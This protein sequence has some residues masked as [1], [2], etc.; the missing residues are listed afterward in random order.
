MYGTI[1]ARGNHV[2]RRGNYVF[3]SFDA[4][5]RATSL[6]T[7]VG[8]YRLNIEDSPQW[9]DALL[10]MTVLAHEMQSSLV[11]TPPAELPFYRIRF[12][13]SRLAPSE[14]CIYR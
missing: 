3:D 9:R 13:S 5:E 14:R 7:D 11:L 1:A 10:Q 12:D 2:F 6:D 4:K 8:F